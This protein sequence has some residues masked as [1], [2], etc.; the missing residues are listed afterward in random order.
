MRSSSSAY[1]SLANCVEQVRTHK[2][3]GPYAVFT[4]AGDV[5]QVRRQCLFCWKPIGACVPRAS[6]P[7]A[8]AAI[9]GEPNLSDLPSNAKHVAAFAEVES[10]GKPFAN[11][12]YPPTLIA[13]VEHTR[14]L[15][16]AE[17]FS[18]PDWKVLRS[19]V[20]SRAAG[21]CEACGKVGPADVHHAHYRTFGREG[22]DDLLSL[23]R[24]CHDEVHR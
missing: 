13:Y 17:R 21:R 23:C 6:A 14:K 9:V 7:W 8:A 16:Y 22:I 5:K 11:A 15:R 19:M 12:G 20:L 10:G 18:R 4:V 1:E 2:C 3:A 24:A